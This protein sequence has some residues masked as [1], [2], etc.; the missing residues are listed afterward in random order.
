M[1]RQ[2]R[3]VRG[4]KGVRIRDMVLARI[5]G[6]PRAVKARILRQS[7][8]TAVLTV[9]LLEPVGAYKKGQLIH[10]APSYCHMEEQ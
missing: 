1:A 6:T 10:I 5:A 7:G 3:E 9:E 4:M 2:M 8:V